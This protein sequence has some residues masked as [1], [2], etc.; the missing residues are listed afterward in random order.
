MWPSTA[1]CSAWAPPCPPLQKCWS[2]PLPAIQDQQLLEMH[3]D[4]VPTEACV[5]APPA[6]LRVQRQ[7]AHSLACARARAS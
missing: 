4:P 2:A 1:R 3:S 5:G 7:A 6:A